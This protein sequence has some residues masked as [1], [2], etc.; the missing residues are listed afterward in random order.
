MLC[1]SSGDGHATMPAETGSEFPINWDRARARDRRASRGREVCSGAERVGKIED[2]VVGGLNL[3]PPLLGDESTH[4]GSGCRPSPVEERSGACF[5][6]AT[7]N[8]TPASG[9]QRLRPSPM[10]SRI[11]RRCSM[12]GLAS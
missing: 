11:T 3:H 12:G 7:L 4:H 8:A 10:E 5:A 6:K 9:K 1:A 2:S